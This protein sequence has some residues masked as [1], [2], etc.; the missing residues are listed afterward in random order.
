MVFCAIAFLVAMLLFLLFAAGN[1]EEG[2][3]LAGG[4]AFIVGIILAI[5]TICQHITWN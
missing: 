3:A 4:A 1:I 5:G 2:V